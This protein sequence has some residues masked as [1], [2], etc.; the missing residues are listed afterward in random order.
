LLLLS[1]L[2]ETSKSRAA[3]AAT[4]LKAATVEKDCQGKYFSAFLTFFS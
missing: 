2:R 1:G 4:R 3:A